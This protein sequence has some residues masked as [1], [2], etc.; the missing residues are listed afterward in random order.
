M[1]PTR[2]Q[3]HPGQVDMV[4]IVD[5]DGQRITFDAAHMPDV[6]PDEVA[7]LKEMVTTATFT[8]AEDT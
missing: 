1:W 7:E 4:W 6:S 3:Q 2:W 5:V 8:P